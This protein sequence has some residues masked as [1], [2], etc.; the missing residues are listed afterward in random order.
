MIM[1]YPVAAECLAR[2]SCDSVLFA[3]SH[4]ACWDG[5]DIG[6]QGSSGKV[7][8]IVDQGIHQLKATS[9]HRLRGVRVIGRAARDQQSYLM[10]M[11]ERKHLW[12]NTGCHAQDL[13]CAHA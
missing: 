8:H 5:P 10:S 1:A 6:R 9:L 7:S 11:T 3:N 2:D 12:E 13:C 4:G